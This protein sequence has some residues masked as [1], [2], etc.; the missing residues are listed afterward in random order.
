MVSLEDRKKMLN[1][2]KVQ[3]QED[4]RAVYL[5]MIIYKIDTLVIPLSPP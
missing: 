2:R 5:G 1:Q 4:G 3:T